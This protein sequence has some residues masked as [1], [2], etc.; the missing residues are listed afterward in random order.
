MGKKQWKTVAVSVATLLL[1]SLL[2][3]WVF[4]DHYREILR[5]IRAVSIPELLLLLGMGVLYQLLEA[6]VCFSLVNTQLPSF[7]FWQAAEVTFLGVFGNVSTLSAGTIPM[8]SYYL[9]RHGLMAGR[10]IG[11]MALEYVFHKCSIL[12]YTTCL[13][14]LQG[15][16]LRETGAGLSGYM[17]LGYAICTL[18]IAALLLLCAW[19]K[20]QQLAS[21][22]IDRL[23]NTEKWASRK[24]LWKTNLAA[25]YE[26]SQRLLWDGS[27]L[28][29]VLAWN[30]LK[31]CCLYSIPFLAMKMLGISGPA[32]WQV[33]LLTALMHLISNALPNVAGVGPVEFAFVLIFSHYMEYAQASSALI[34]YRVATFFFPFVLSIFV[35]LRV[36]KRMLNDPL[37]T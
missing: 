8:Q 37:K 10:G 13:L 19:D 4:R 3:F 9:H 33:Q 14:L 12:L 16:W 6:A 34:L 18:I 30:A 28:S 2:V 35:F 17:L 15:R 24:C 7:S 25:L 32:F 36:Q 20:V 11:T 1:L 21:W 26:Q 31:L 22:G 29:K 5:N 23:P 27:G